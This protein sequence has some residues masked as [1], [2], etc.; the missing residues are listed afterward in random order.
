M[1]GCN[2][3]LR[4]T[5]APA[6]HAAATHMEQRLQPH[7]TAL[8]PVGGGGGGGEVGLLAPGLFFYHHIAKTGGTSWSNDI[9]QLGAPCV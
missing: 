7:S 1:L 9:V 4:A 6:G 8:A 2:S 3:L 5:H